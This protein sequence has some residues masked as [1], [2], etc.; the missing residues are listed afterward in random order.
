MAVDA[1]IRGLEAQN[2]ALQGLQIPITLMR[3]RIR[4]CI[5]IKVKSWI[6]ISIEVM[7]IRKPGF[8]SRLMISEIL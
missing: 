1:L 7:Q 2:G 6:W 5:R 4:I 3:S 8:K